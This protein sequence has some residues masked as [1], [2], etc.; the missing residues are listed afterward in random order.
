MYNA[1]SSRISMRFK[2]T[3]PNYVVVSACTSSTTAIGLGFRMIRD[4]YADRVLCGGTEAIFEPGVFRAWDSLG[5]MSRNP[6]PARACRPFDKD[7]DGCILGEGAG[8]LLLESLDNARQRS[9]GIR[10]EISGYGESSDTTHITR[11]N[12]EGQAQAMRAALSDAGLSPADV[13]F[14]NTHGTA[15]ESND[16]CESQSIRAVLG[17]AAGTIPAA[18]S[19]SFVGHL[20]GA[21]GVV[22]TAVTILG[23]EAGTVPG[24][25]NLDNR[26]PRC[27][28]LFVGKEPMTV[29]SPIA[30][31]NSFGF[32]GNNAVLIVRRWED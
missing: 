10:A 29:T 3:G 18:S 25:L 24:N 5:V 15:T 4:G 22:E 32:G 16:L 27:N 21:S 8:T 9:A 6:D 12:P 7:R 1:I 26:D 30:M 13:G 2:L 31:K 28:L 14:V 11:P 17:S 23:L 20:L 19:K